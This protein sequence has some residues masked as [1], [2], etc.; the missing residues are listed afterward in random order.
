MKDEPR[1]LSELAPLTPPGLDRVIRA[2]LVK[3]PNQRWQS[4]HD[5]AV[6]L[7]WPVAE[8][9]AAGRSTSALIEREFILTAAHV[10]LLAER[11][12]RLVGYPVTYVDNQVQCVLLNRLPAEI[13]LMIWEV[14]IG[15][16]K[17]HIFY[18]R[19][20]KHLRMTH[21]DCRHDY[22][23]CPGYPCKGAEK[24]DMLPL[25]KTCRQM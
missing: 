5:V 21:R 22:S 15:G 6:A 16:R 18:K 7:R 14:V 17:L 24:G 4:A 12:P 2:C 13:R 11:N 3:D 9:G 1:P 8:S 23:P 19:E 20:S 25:L 10:R